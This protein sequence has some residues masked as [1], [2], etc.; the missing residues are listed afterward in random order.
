M[1]VANK[2]KKLMQDK[3]LS[4]VNFLKASLPFQE[5]IGISMS[6]GY[7]SKCLSGKATISLKHIKLFAKTLNVN[8]SYFF[9]TNENTTIVEIVE[10]TKRL[11]KESQEE[12]LEFTHYLLEGELPLY[13]RKKPPVKNTEE[14]AEEFV[15]FEHDG[16]KQSIQAAAIDVETEYL[17][18]FTTLNHAAG[19]ASYNDET[20]P[21]ESWEIPSSLIK[22]GVKYG[23]PIS[24]DSMGE[25]YPDGAI[26]LVKP[27]DDWN[28][29]IGKVC[30]V[31]IDDE[32]YIKEIGKG[33]LISHNKKYK[34]ITITEHT[35]S[36]ITGEVVAVYE[37]K[38]HD[39][40][41]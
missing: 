6:R 8:E 24:C 9:T 19:R 27:L 10:N 5:E 4:Q 36:R 21:P 25:H 29:G 3:K 34:D 26:A 41:N 28:D 35:D 11:K 22:S 38:K 30:T 37:Y 40:Y 18:V 31:Q 7:L 14:F 32:Y 20:E 16:I 15:T 2:V 39:T 23:V 12:V 17:P 13:K 33:K 1:N